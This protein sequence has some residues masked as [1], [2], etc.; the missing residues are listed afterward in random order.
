MKEVGNR[1]YLPVKVE[2]ATRH[3]VEVIEMPRSPPGLVSIP[4]DF[5]QQEEE[6]AP[7]ERGR[8][9]GFES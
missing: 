5:I 6:V 2:G 8:G 1:F 4:D 9:E 7:E 3:A